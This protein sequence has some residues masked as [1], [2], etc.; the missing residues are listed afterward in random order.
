MPGKPRT[1]TPM[2][3][4]RAASPMEVLRVERLVEKHKKLCYWSVAKTLNINSGHPDFYDAVQEAFITLMR[5]ARQ[6]DPGRGVSFSTYAQTAIYRALGRFSMKCWNRNM[7]CPYAN[8]REEMMPVQL[9][10]EGDIAEMVSV[11]DDNSESDREYT[12][13]IVRECIQKIVPAKYRRSEPERFKRDAVRTARYRE[14]LEK[15]YLQ[16]MTLSEIAEGMG[17]T[18]QRVNQILYN[19]RIKLSVHLEAAGLGECEGTTITKNREMKSNNKETK[20]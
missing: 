13:R 9:K 7:R 16:Q 14:V 15:H 2:D 12:A 8:Y 3:K 1:P 20:L 19:A 10:D 18:R 17:V 5:V 11:T 4:L 6:F